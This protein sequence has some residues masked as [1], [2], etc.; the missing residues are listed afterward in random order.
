MTNAGRFWLA[1]GIT[2]F[3]WFVYRTYVGWPTMSDDIRYGNMF[4]ICLV[5]AI[6]LFCDLATTIGR[7]AEGGDLPLI[8]PIGWMTF[9]VRKFN[10]LLNKHDW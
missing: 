2:A 1:V 9:L 4:F 10:A 3:L 6:W 5:S 8:G 7:Y